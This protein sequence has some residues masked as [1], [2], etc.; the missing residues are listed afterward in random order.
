VVLL[1]KGIQIK[2]MHW[3]NFV[4][5]LINIFVDEQLLG[6][7]ETVVLNIQVPLHVHILVLLPESCI[8]NG[9]HVLVVDPHF[10]S[11][12]THG[13]GLPRS[14]MAQHWFFAGMATRARAT[15]EKNKVD[16]MGRVSTQVI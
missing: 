3:S 7:L 14:R 9:V 16:I 15:C 8:L 2:R 11:F 10:L 5:L 4:H 12:P 13:G 6:A 1:S